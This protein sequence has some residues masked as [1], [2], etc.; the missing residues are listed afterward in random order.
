MCIQKRFV[1]R[2]AILVLYFYDLS[3]KP[4]ADLSE[5][6]RLS[7][8]NCVVMAHRTCS[9]PCMVRTSASR[10]GREAEPQLK[11]SFIMIINPPLR[12]F[13]FQMVQDTRTTRI[14]VGPSQPVATGCSC[15]FTTRPSHKAASKHGFKFRKISNWALDGCIIC[16]ADHIYVSDP[17]TPYS[18]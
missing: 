13:A 6:S 14:A 1:R 15:T 18:V 7:F 9:D 12:I 17:S 3:R 8:F 10:A 11:T 5:K 4:Q 16:N 2:K